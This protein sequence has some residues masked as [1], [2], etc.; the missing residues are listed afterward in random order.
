MMTKGDGDGAMLSQPSPFARPGDADLDEVERAAWLEFN[1]APVNSGGH[2]S[3]LLPWLAQAARD[4][5]DRPAVSADGQVLTYAELHERAEALAAHLRGS[6]VRPGDT[7]AVVATRTVVPYPALLAVISVG[8]AYVPL[9]PDDPTD[10]LRLMLEDCGA[11]T[12]LSDVSSA[13]KVQPLTGL[14]PTCAVLDAGGAVD[15]WQDW[16]GVPAADRLAPVPEAGAPEDTTAY[17][18]YTSGTTGR[19]K[20]VRVAES[21]VL[22][23]VR[24][25]HD[26]HG[27]VA[28][29]RVAQNAPLTFDPSVQQIFP[30]WTAG[31]CLVVMPEVALLDSHELLVWLREEEI[32][33]LD[34]V[35]SHWFHLLD[36]AV[37]NPGLRD[38]PHLR[39]TLVGGESF[40]YQST[41]QWYDVVRSPG[42]LNNVYGPTEATVNATCIVVP[43]ERTDGKVP[44]GKPLP[45]YRLYVLDDAGGLCAI[46]EQGELYIAGAGLAQGYCSEEAT[47]KVWLDHC[48]FGDTTERLYRT[49]DLA[50]LVRDVDGSPVLE[51]RGRADRQV[52]I[53]GYR[54]ELEEVEMAAKACRD[55]RDAAVMTLGDPPTQLVCFVVGDLDG[56]AAVRAEMSEKLPAYMVPHIV[57][58]VGSMPFTAS[59]KIDR[60]RLLQH[61]EQVRADQAVLGRSLTPTE[62]L[63]ADVLGQ[64]LRVPVTSSTADFYLL[65]GSSLLALQVAGMLR[66]AGMP[67]RATDLL[68]HSRVEQLAAHLDRERIVR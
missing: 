40:T 60:A 48:V 59:G 16:S 44:I 9:N 14:V 2:P 32:T 26:L 12:V 50:R 30:A 22:N 6:G 8:A 27:T 18:I 66:D 17:V 10:R 68:Y 15:G 31:A 57:L 55:V 35:T 41:R 34:M 46:G 45:H 7:V 51:F 61:L 58:P 19:P 67:M 62:Q 3:R 5:R 23:L 63:V 38:L 33:H 42:L 37:S 49:G 20:G 65:G 11:L 56:P 1:Q 29:D 47:R 53:S 28:G 39:W 24:W 43:P 25:F 4:H 21:S 52:K 64:V 36:A 13:P 54:L